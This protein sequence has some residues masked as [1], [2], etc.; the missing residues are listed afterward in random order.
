MMLHPAPS[1]NWGRI[2]ANAHQSRW[3][4]VVEAGEPGETP[5]GR[6]QEMQNKGCLPQSQTHNLLVRRCWTQP[7]VTCVESVL[8]CMWG[9][10]GLP[11]RRVDS[12]ITASA[13][14]KSN[15][16]WNKCLLLFTFLL[17][18]RGHVAQFWQ[19]YLMLLT[20]SW[21]HTD[22]TFRHKHHVTIVREAWKDM[23][24]TIQWIK[25]KQS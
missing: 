1:G 24:G 3:F 9:R 21:I 4:S 16:E 20:T 18:R 12:A 7:H 14:I 2:L 15:R 10:D 11:H 19:K 25:R 23:K 13:I 6:R 8:V 17:N 22:S 5:C